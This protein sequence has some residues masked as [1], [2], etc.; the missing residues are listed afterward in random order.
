MKSTI[1]PVA[2][3]WSIAQEAATSVDI[4][5]RDV[6]T[7]ITNDPVM[8][9]MG[10]ACVFKLEDGYVARIKDWLQDQGH[11]RR[12]FDET[13]LRTNNPTLIKEL[14]EILTMRSG[15]HSYLACFSTGLKA[16][17]TPD[18]FEAVKWHEYGHVKGRH[19]EGFRFGGY[20]EFITNEKEADAYA[21]EKGPGAQ[22][23]ITGLEKAMKFGAEQAVLWQ[24]GASGGFLRKLIDSGIVD[25][26]TIKWTIMQNKALHQARFTELQ[27]VIKAQKQAGVASTEQKNKEPA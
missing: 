7:L 12:S 6:H 27:K 11:G 9:G 3:Q 21:V 18:E 10:G 24:Q 4:N 19:L 16:Q 20:H 25:N 26:L 17:L 1:T 14:E 23:M 8:A 22:A 13:K 5:N 15:L 2:L